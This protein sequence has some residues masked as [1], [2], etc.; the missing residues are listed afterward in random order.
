[1]NEFKNKETELY[2]RYKQGD[3]N[4]KIELISSLAPLINS[5]VNKFNTSGLPPIAIKLEG[6]RLASMAIDCYDPNKSQLNTHVMNYLQKLSRFVNTYNNVGHIPEPRILL[7]GKYNNIKSNLEADKGREA[8][9]T[10]LSDAMQLPILEIERLQTELRKDLSTTLIAEDEDDTGF[11]EY[12]ENIGNDP[13][14]KEAIDFV[15]FDADP[16]DK[17]ILEKTLGLYGNIKVTGK[18]LTRSLFIT[19]ADLK[20]RKE[21][22]AKEIKELL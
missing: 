4:A 18:D 10:E 3:Q 21:K 16:V 13:K 9:L 22:L 15:Y 12:T 6:Q 2:N 14:L 8:T 1:M 7:I 11:Y 19:D 5:S 17:K 20:K